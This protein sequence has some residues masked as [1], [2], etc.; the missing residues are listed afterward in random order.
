M[1]INSNGV[2]FRQR[3]CQ[4]SLSND[5]N[6][7]RI[8][9]GRKSDRRKYRTSSKRSPIIRMKTRIMNRDGNLTSTVGLVNTKPM[10]F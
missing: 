1:R 2:Y 10:N 3:I 8:I 4:P 9:C 7:K 5:N 6:Y